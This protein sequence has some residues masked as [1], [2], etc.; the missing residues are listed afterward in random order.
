[1]CQTINKIQ[2]HCLIHNFLINHRNHK[3][4]FL[5]RKI[6]KIREILWKYRC[7]CKIREEALSFRKMIYVIFPNLTKDIIDYKICYKMRRK[8]VWISFI[9]I[10]RDK[11]KLIMINLRNLPI[12]NS[13]KILLRTSKLKNDRSNLN[14]RK[15]KH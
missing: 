12:I 6:L 13:L 8:I 11:I 2:H 4:N 14:L 7:L 15:R 9:K 10:F 3:V 1:M 5:K